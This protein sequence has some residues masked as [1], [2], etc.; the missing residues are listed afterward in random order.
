[1]PAT[2]RRRTLDELARLGGELFDRHVRPSLRPE[3]D[4]RF[5]AIDVETGEYEINED[6][7]AA[8]M[9][10]R[11]RCPAADIWLMRAGY[12]AAYR[13]GAVRRSEASLMPTTK[14][15]SGCGCVVLQVSSRTWKRLSIPVSR[16]P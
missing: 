13:I 3:D 10:L 11:A 6:D 5:V 15:L 4:G 9:D 14:P 12:P 16:H 2:E 7:Y 8:V 1:M